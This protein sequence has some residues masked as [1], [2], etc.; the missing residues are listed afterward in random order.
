MASKKKRGT[1]SGS[2]KRAKPK[3]KTKAKVKAKVKA[4]ARAKPKAAARSKSKAARA[5]PKATR[6]KPK[7]ARAKKKPQQ[8]T[9]AVAPVKPQI[10]DDVIEESLL[11]VSG[12]LRLKDTAARSQRDVDE[13]DLK[14]FPDPS[15][16]VE[17][18]QRPALHDEDSGELPSLFAAEARRQKAE[19]PDDEPQRDDGPLFGRIGSDS[20]DDS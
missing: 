16:V 1:K 2:K 11:D 19:P 7:A 20:D 5:K 12:I 6:A 10:L 13:D 4:K 14:Q 18:E 8:P 15:L 17:A 3:T 9:A